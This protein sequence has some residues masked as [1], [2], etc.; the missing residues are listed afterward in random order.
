MITLDFVSFAPWVMTLCKLTTKT[1][2]VINQ[3]PIG[4]SKI[5][6]C[7]HLREA[8]NSSTDGTP[9]IQSIGKIKL[10]FMFISI[11]F[12][13]TT[14]TIN[15]IWVVIITL[16]FPCVKE[17][18][19]LIDLMINHWV[20][21]DFSINF[22]KPHTYHTKLVVFTCNVKWVILMSHINQLK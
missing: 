1:D 15:N 14:G 17:N 6:L 20:L 22:L 5:H 12:K 13:S 16:F 3:N 7:I 19:K 4:K 11:E 10:A 2:T 21:H 18:G 8:K 9:L